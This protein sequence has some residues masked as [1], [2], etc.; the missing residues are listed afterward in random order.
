MKHLSSAILTILFLTIIACNGYSMTR[1]LKQDPAIVIVAF[2]TTT[3]ASS[4]F[5]FFDNQLKRE[6]PD[7]Y[8]NLKINWAFTSN[9]VRER[10]N[11]RREKD[12]NPDRLLSL[13]QVLANLMDQGYKKVAIQPLH[14]FPGEEYEDMAHVID[15]F[16][17]LG[18]DIRYGG[19]LMSKWEDFPIALKAIE[20]E[21]LT[22]QE[23][24]N[25]I[26]A[27]GTPQTYNDSNNTYIGLDRYISHRYKN[28]YIGTVS[29]ILTR[30]ELMDNIKGC[31]VKSSGA[32]SIKIKIIPFLLVAGDHII[33]DVMGD[34]ANKDGIIS[35]KMELEKNGF[36]VLSPKDNVFKGLGYNPDI[37]RMFIMRLIKTLDG[38]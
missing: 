13:P 22:P 5:D 23:G 11:E 19:T 29:G 38:F 20:P 9:I 6:L 17:T 3:S 1:T 14:I 8:K 30:E 4:T 2:G 27:H 7:K 35:W 24:C 26:A 15:A 28:V 25:I 37:N 21:F 12:G 34:T 33:N 18:L 32:T 16:K 36:T 31:K 10:I